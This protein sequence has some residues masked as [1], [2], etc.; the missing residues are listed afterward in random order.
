MAFDLTCLQ[1][2]QAKIRLR[3]S[4]RGGRAGGDH[5][6][7]GLGDA[8]G[9]GVL[10]QQAAGDL[11]EDGAERSGADLDEAEVLLGGEAVAGLGSECRGG[12]GFDEE[13]GDL[14]GGRGRRPRGLMPMTPPK[15]ETGSQARAFW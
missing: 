2:R 9:V 3:I 11:L 14:L 10:K 6:E 5:F 13:L 7:V 15:A 4:S 8:G 12:D 1:T